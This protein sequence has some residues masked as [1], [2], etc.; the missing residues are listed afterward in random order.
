MTTKAAP[1]RATRSS[2]GAS[3][4]KDSPGGTATKSTYEPLIIA[5]DTEGS[6]LYPDEGARVSTVSWAYRDPQTGLVVADAMP[7]G[8]GPPNLLGENDRG[9]EQFEE[10]MIWLSCHRLVFHNAKYDMHMLGAGAIPGYPGAELGRLFYWDTMVAQRFLDPLCNVG[11]DDTCIRLGLGRKDTAF[12][13]YIK[14]H[15][16]SKAYHKVPWDVMQPYALADAK[17]TLALYENQVAR[18]EGDEDDWPEMD[19]LMRQFEVTRSLYK[20][21]QRGIGFNAGECLLAA[22]DLKVA[23][24]ELQEQLPFKAGSL[25]QAKRYFFG[26]PPN[27]LGLFHPKT[28]LGGEPALD[29]QVRRDLVRQHAPLAKEYDRWCELE[30]AYSMWYNA[31]PNMIGPDSRLRTNFRQTKVVSGRFS[32]ERVQLQA[33][34]HDYQL[35]QL[36]PGLPT[37][38]SFFEAKEG[39]V[40]WELDLSQAEVRVASWWSKCKTMIKAIQSGTDAHDATTTLIFGVTKDSP[41][42]KRLRSVAKRIRLGTI[43][44]GGA[45]KIKDELM[46]MEGLDYP[47]EQVK[48]WIDADRAVF[49][50]F[51]RASRKAQAIAEQNGWVPLAGGGYRWFTDLEKQKGDMHKAFNQIIQGSVAAIMNEWMIAVEQQYNGVLLLQIHDSLVIEVPED[52]DVTPKEIARLGESI[53]EAKFGMPFICDSKQWG[54]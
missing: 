32:V 48:E 36:L 12:G 7:F 34:P 25:V 43:Y 15:R 42:W 24:D 52:D 33:I 3:R 46:R 20:M 44:G 29:E 23:M 21:E 35:D 47:L 49:P 19:W 31:W 30:T 54:A 41:D 51:M 8:Q 39:H 13:D 6:G 2:S 27:G 5:V 37:I 4:R 28:T 40:L 18:I 45:G 14:K 17:M 11:L 50:E 53:F 9:P 10:L 26:E 16:L 1:R 38:R 22:H